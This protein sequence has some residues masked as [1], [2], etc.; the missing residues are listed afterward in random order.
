VHSQGLAA[1]ANVTGHE[2]SEARTDPRAAGWYDASGA[3]NS[4]KCAWAFGT[5]LIR[6]SHNS[7]W[8]IQ[9]NWS[10]AAYTGN[11]GYLNR[12]GQPGCLDGGNYPAMAP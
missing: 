11:A 6:F 7:E 9:G 10:N 5:P 1:L 4:D 2:L 12:S 8:K 3:E